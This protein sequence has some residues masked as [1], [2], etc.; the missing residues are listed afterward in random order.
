MTDEEVD[1]LLKVVDTSNGQINYT[2]RSSAPPP[3]SLFFFEETPPAPLFPPP[4][5]QLSPFLN[6]PQ[7]GLID[8]VSTVDAD[9]STYQILFELFWQI[10]K[11]CLH[12]TTAAII[13]RIFF[14]LF[15]HRLSLVP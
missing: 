2:G 1:E 6:P 13:H 5:A 7:D 12:S 3:F 10:E 14:L 11:V 4:G 15:S 9:G 8:L